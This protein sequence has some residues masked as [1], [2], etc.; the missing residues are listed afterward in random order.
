MTEVIQRQG[1]AGFGRLRGKAA[2]ITAAARGIGRNSSITG[3]R[4]GGEWNE[5]LT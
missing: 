2:I 1:A 3:P 4:C 5:Q